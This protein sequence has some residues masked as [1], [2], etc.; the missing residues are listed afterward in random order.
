MPDFYRSGLMPLAHRYYARLKELLPADF[1]VTFPEWGR[2]PWGV[3]F[4]IR[5]NNNLAMDLIDRPAFVHRLMR[6][7]TDARKEWWLAR[8]K[9]LGT[10]LEP[11][12]LYNDE[13]NTPTMSPGQYEEFV[14]PYEQ[15]LS[16]FH[17]GIG[18]W[19]SCGDTTLLV[20]L[21]DRIPNMSMF[22]VGPW[23][24][25]R[26]VVEVFSERHPLELCL[27]PVND[28]Q[29]APVERMRAH[30]QDIRQ[31]CG[32]IAYTVRAD[33]LQNLQGKDFEVTQIQQWCAVADEVL[34]AGAR[35]PVG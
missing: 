28:V 8:C 12:N 1:T 21:I 26:R 3:A 18:Y 6:F 24:N 34:L 35:V 13:V 7:I 23:T 29:L 9:F 32:N 30:L 2:G 17:G 25:L 22:H 27:N 16:E 31:V 5:L 4:H 14:L 15:E 19:H 10:R 20:H 33:G 11:A